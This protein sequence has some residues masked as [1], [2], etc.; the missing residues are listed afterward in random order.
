MIQRGGNNTCQET[1]R[2]PETVFETTRNEKKKKT[3]SGKKIQTTEQRNTYGIKNHKQN[4]NKT[5]QT[6]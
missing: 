4:K 5:K 3:D 1:F 6:V 2:I